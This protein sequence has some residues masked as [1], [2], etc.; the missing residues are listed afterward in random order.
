MSAPAHCS[1]V[2]VTGLYLLRI[3]EYEGEY[4]LGL[5]IVD[6]KDAKDGEQD[7]EDTWSISWFTRTA[8]KARKEDQWGDNPV[9]EPHKVGPSRGA[10]R[11]TDSGIKL[12]SFILRVEDSD[13]TAQGR[14][15]RTH[16]VPF[17]PPKTLHIEVHT[18][19]LVG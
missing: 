6:R 13:L 16:A 11:A 1:T 12:P 8:W 10:R 17:V 14:A 2:E 9:F 19:M 3:E 5:A 7:A 15:V 4:N 18:A